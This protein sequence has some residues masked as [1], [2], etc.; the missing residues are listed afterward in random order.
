M[1]KE[2]ILNIIH[3]HE[4]SE[5]VEYKENNVDP[6]RIGKY[7]SAL[8]NGAI[9]THNPCSYMIWGVE[10]VTKKLTGTTFNPELAKASANQK[11]RCL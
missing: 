5:I 9:M 11:T 7:I 8:G 2:D 6:K 3:T 1:L 10:D 4:E